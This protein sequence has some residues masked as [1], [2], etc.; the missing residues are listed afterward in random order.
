MGLWAPG[1]RGGLVRCGQVC[2]RSIVGSAAPLRP[3]TPNPGTRGMV[4]VRDLLPSACR[5]YAPCI[6]VLGNLLRAHVAAYQ[7]M[8][9][10]PGGD[11]AQIGMVHQHI[12]FHAKCGR[13]AKL[14]VQ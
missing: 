9:E 6:Q 12:R 11:Q 1:M 8:K 4:C 14:W 10:M 2:A 3:P 7:A 5:P 13:I